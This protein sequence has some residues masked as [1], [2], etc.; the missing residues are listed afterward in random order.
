MRSTLGCV[1]SGAGSARTQQPSSDDVLQLA[2]SRPRE[3]TLRVQRILASR[4]GPYEASVAHQAAGI[5]HRDNGDITAGVRELRLALRLARRSGSAERE[6]DVLSSLGAALVYLGRTGSGLA[7]FERAAQLA[8]DSQLGRVLQRRG[9]LLWTLGRYAAALEDLRRAIALLVRAGD[10]AWTARALNTRGVV[11]LAVGA[12]LRADADFAA[13]GRMYAD[14]HQ[15]LALAHTVLNRGL[16]ALRSGDLPTALTFFDDAAVRY[17][18]VDVP[19]PELSQARCAALRTAGLTGEALAEADVAIGENER[20]HGQ[21]TRRADLL[22]VAADCALAADQPQT[23]LARAGAAGRLFRAQRRDRYLLQATMLAVQAHYAAGSVSGRLLLSAGRVAARLDDLASV[24]AVRAHLL[25][26]RVALDLGRRSQA[27]VHLLAVAR[28]RRRGPAISRATGWLSTA[29]LAEAAGQPRPMLAA[30]RRGLQV[31]DEHRWTLG[32]SELR[33]QA[34]AHG[35][36]LAALALRHAARAGRPRA[37]LTWAER[38]RATAV[39]AVPAVRPP[40][41][42]ELNAELAALRAV[43]VRLDE[44]RAQGRPTTTMEREQLRL[45]GAVRSRS[46]LARG[47]ARDGAGGFDIAAMLDR[48]GDSQLVEIVDVD[49]TLHVLVCSA[50]RVRQFTAGR[51]ADAVRAAEYAGFALRRLA[52]NRPGSDPGSTRAVLDTTGPQLEAALLG[53]AAGY[54]TGGPVVVA[55]PGR[56]HAIPWALLPALGSRVFSVVPSAA[57]WLRAATAEPPARRRVTL[58]CGPGLVTGGA[59]IAPVAGLYD[60]VAVLTGAQATAAGVLSALDGA[61]LGHIA[62]HGRFRADSPLFSSLRMHDG[63]LTVYDFEQLSRAPYRLVLS[64]CDSGV[65]APAGADELLG[66]VASL[67][68]LGTAGLIAGV[69]Q[70]NDHAVVPLMVALHQRLRAGESLAQSMYSVRREAA[71]DPAQQAAALSLLAFG[72]G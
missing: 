21:P 50:G 66:L 52:R 56:L 17:Q 35:T 61:W 1:A 8:S 9:T 12:P 32:A 30:C 11:H 43:T 41:D 67:L 10:L 22:L 36:E 27:E 13:A 57:A 34:T 16:A 51:T 25:A 72:A 46:L 18:R 69:I 29:L 71:A 2:V 42:P 68:P 58:A 59:E 45:E 15:E 33:A 47:G 24:E 26:G 39:T 55:P 38:W 40:A 64:S 49:G 65:L 63:P 62:A 53:P 28:T 37:F 5:V 70:L 7:A 19:T 23:A 6:A 3:V 44:A 20:V 4:P 60:D 48:L 54:L 14:T 31:L